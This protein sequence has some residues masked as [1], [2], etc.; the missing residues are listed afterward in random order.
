MDNDK[1]FQVVASNP[2]VPKHPPNYYVQHIPI[3]RSKS[4]GYFGR[5]QLLLSRECLL[6]KK[7]KK[8]TGV[9]RLQPSSGNFR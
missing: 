7:K 5:N 4:F 3:L 1:Q 2:V 6:K 9:S 8:S